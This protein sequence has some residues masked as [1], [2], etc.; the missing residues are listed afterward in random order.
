MNERLLYPYLD[1]WRLMQDH[2]SPREYPLRVLL[3]CRYCDKLSTAGSLSVG[4][5]CTQV[6]PAVLPDA[7][8][9]GSNYSRSL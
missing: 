5:Y 6:L 2:I 1:P 3:V 4:E 9:E 7:T 8:V